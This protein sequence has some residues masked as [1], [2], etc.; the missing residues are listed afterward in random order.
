MI[1]D[2]HRKYLF[3]HIP[4]TSGISLSRMVMQQ[5]DFQY[6]MGPDVI[7]GQCLWWPLWRH[8][9]AALL[10]EHFPEWDTLHKFAIMRNP[11]RLIESMYRKLKDTADKHPHDPAL[12]RVLDQSFEL[13]LYDH[14]SYMQGGFWK[15]WCLSDD[16]E[17]LGVECLRYEDA[18][19]TWSRIQEITGLTGERLI[20][21]QSTDESPLIWTNTM[22]DFVRLRFAN[23]FA[24]FDY[25]RQPHESGVV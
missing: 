6:G 9:R 10:A 11:W 16:G 4:R 24:R 17:D 13:F 22:I 8:S 25:P 18:G 23:D 2:G 14:Y 5:V 7:L 21:N 12:S 1:H 15:H 3:I 19:Q 20:A